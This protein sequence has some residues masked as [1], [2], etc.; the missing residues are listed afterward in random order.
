MDGAA[1]EK[2]REGGR[3]VKGK[4]EYASLI[5]RSGLLISRSFGSEGYNRWDVGVF[6]KAM[7]KKRSWKKDE[8]L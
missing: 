1:T 3:T 4:E 6:L 7:G 5:S 2:E 8:R